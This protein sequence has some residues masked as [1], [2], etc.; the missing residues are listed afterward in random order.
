MPDNIIQII[1]CFGSLLT[2]LYT[3]VRIYSAIRHGYIDISNRKN[4]PNESSLNKVIK[5]ETDN[6]NHE[7]KLILDFFSKQKRL[8]TIYAAITSIVTYRKCRSQRFEA[9]I[10]IATSLLMCLMCSASASNKIVE[11]EIL[12]VII[13][14]IFYFILVISIIALM[15]GD[16]TFICSL[17]I[18]CGL[19]G[20]KKRIKGSTTTFAIT[21]MQGNLRRKQKPFTIIGMY[22]PNGSNFFKDY[23]YITPF[24]WQSIINSNKKYW[25]AID[26]YIFAR[27]TQE[28]QRICNLFNQNNIN[29]FTL[30]GDTRDT[31]ARMSFFRRLLYT[32][33]CGFGQLDG[34]PMY[35]ETDK[36]ILQ[37]EK[38][39][40]RSEEI[41]IVKSSKRK[42]IINY[43][44]GILRLIRK[45]QLKTISKTGLKSLKDSKLE[46]GLLVVSS[47]NK[48]E[49][50]ELDEV[51][52]KSDPI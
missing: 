10:L 6:Y 43:G 48:T 26:V 2:M 15:Y 31:S 37:P 22:N 9:V 52:R 5:C 4:S 25:Q 23:S 32:K 50:F 49:Q 45:S 8:Q 3:I 21:E 38:T 27:T 11:F 51:Y 7:E 39:F 13:I 46:N 34:F 19:L 16:F 28:A 29:A 42:I 17:C 20:Q 18:W 36:L 30:L 12:L 24:E 33:V 1:G 14:L 44:F 47:N 41:L 35:V 40:C